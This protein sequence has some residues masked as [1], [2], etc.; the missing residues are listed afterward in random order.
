MITTDPKQYLDPQVAR[1]LVYDCE[2]AFENQLS[3]LCRTVGLGDYQIILLSGPTCSGKTTTTNKLVQ[4]LNDR[5]N[6]VHIVSVDDFYY[7]RMYLMARSEQLGQDVD[8]ESIAAIDLPFFKM[9]MQS[10]L[11]G[12]K[13]LLPKYDFMLGRRSAYDAYELTDNSVVIVEGIQSVYPEIAQV[14]CNTKNLSVFISTE[15]SVCCGDSVFPPQEL[16]LIRRLVR[17]SRH[18]GATAEF[19]FSLWKSVT[20]N[21]AKSIFPYKDKAQVKIDSSMGYEPYVMRSFLI[22]LLQKDVAKDSPYYSL[23]AS[24][25]KRLEQLPSLDATLIPDGSVYHEFIG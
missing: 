4:T 17:D 14:F 2:E 9:C 15:K 11:E 1:Q 13:T 10:L 21:E 22:P 23:A 24:L 6:D 8:F 18:R 19:T 25:I 20:D 5:G 12:K 16:R 7:D 3:A